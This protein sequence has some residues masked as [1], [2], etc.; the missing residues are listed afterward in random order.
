MVDGS[1]EALIRDLPEVYQPIYG[2]P[3]VAAARATDEDRVSLLITHVTRLSTHLGRPLRVLDL[4]SAQGY[5]AFRMAELGHR[6]TGVEYLAINVAVARAIGARHPELDV[7]F[8]E[9]DV[10]GVLGDRD[11]DI[12]GDLDLAGFDLVVGFSVLHHIADRDG[13]DAADELV[14]RLSGSV[15][16]GLF[17]MAIP[18]EPV[19]WA[20]SL[21]TDPRT[22]LGSYAFVRRIGESGTHLSDVLRPIFFCSQSLALLE[23]ELLP[24]LSQSGRPHADANPILEG[25]HRYYMIPQGM[26]KIAARFDPSGD[27]ALIAGLQTE[28]RQ[29]AHMLGTLREAGLDVPELI[30]FADTDGETLLARSIYPGELVSDIIGSLSDEDRTEITAHVLTALGE[31]EA[32]GLYHQDLRLWNV[33][34]DPAGRQAHVIDFGSL[35]ASPGDSMW[36]FDAY[37]SLAAFLVALWGPGVDLTGREDP[38]SALLDVPDLAKLPS[39]IVSALLRHRRDGSVFRDLAETWTRLCAALPEDAAER[40]LAWEWLIEVERLRGATHAELDAHAAVVK[41]LHDQSDAQE[42][43]RELKRRDAEFRRAL[44]EQ[45]IQYQRQLVERDVQLEVGLAG[46]RHELAQRNAEIVALAGELDRTRQSVSWRI[47]APLRRVR[48]LMR[49][50]P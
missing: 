18:S 34:W 48:V 50:T 5:L 20:G 14:H 25:M 36:P 33:V 15:P 30:E 11:P 45:E 17:E 38:R 3:E 22:T 23:D 40:P 46:H 10:T 4:G 37:F 39:A 28:L 47:T 9:G 32:R 49:R 31:F 29:E 24:I 21:A 26:I 12:D 42:Y 19:H 6:V 8:V 43:E 27:A 1:L 2:M 16:H 41:R 13:Q 7:E 35:E 44:V